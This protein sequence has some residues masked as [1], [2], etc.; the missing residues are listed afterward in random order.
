[1]GAVQL[2][3]PAHTSLSPDPLHKPSIPS[4]HLFNLLRLWGNLSL[5]YSILRTASKL[6][7]DVELPAEYELRDM[8]H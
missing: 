1:M 5:W 2:I 8:Q 4:E 6:D 3:V 7:E